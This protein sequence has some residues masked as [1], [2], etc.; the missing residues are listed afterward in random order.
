MTIDFDTAAAEFKKRS[1][2]PDDFT[3]RRDN[4]KFHARF[5]L[6]D[7]ATVR[8]VEGQRIAEL[9]Q[10]A[11]NVKVF[12]SNCQCAEVF[13]PLAYT[14]I[15][16]ELSQKTVTGKTLAPT[17]GFQLYYLTYQCQRCAGLPIGFV[18]RRE[19]WISSWTDVLQWR[20]SC[21]RHLFLRRRDLSIATL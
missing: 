20:R 17:D 19:G 12:C 8:T 4:L 1:L 3:Q 6:A 9:T 16:E 21:F 11:Q 18:V 10:V 14:D 15:T 13:S 5:K 7:K 2:D